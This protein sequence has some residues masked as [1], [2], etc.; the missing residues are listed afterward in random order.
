[1]SEDKAIQCHELGKRYRIG[2]AH[3][4]AKT[5]RQAVHQAVLSPFSYLR[6]KL[7]PPDESEVLWALRDVSFEV[8]RGEVVGVIGANGAGKSTLLKILSRITEPTEGHAVI[9]GRVNSLLEV[10]TGFHPELTGRENMYMAAAIHGMKRAEVNA[11]FDQIVDF[12]GVGKFLDTPLKRY[13]SGMRVRLG[14]AVAAHLSPDVLIVDEVLAVGDLSFQKRCADRMEKAA[15]SGSTVLVVSHRMESIL[16]LCSR[17]ILLE[18]GRKVMEGPAREVVDKYTADVQVAAGATSL[19]EREDRRG[20]GRFRYVDVAFSDGDGTGL[21]QATVGEPFSIHLGVEGEAALASGLTCLCSLNAASGECAT[22]LS[23]LRIG[24]DVSLS[25]RGELEWHIDRMALT[26]GDYRC[27]LILCR[28]VPG[29]PQMEL[30]DRVTDAFT[31]AVVPGDFYGTGKTPVQGTDRFF[32]DHS[33][34]I[35]SRTT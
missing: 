34:S 11:V 19:R 23:S 33:L 6:M 29:T 7:R 13:S 5:F 2:A 8:E 15:G 9:R 18:N 1:M 26:P 35:H 30:F 28:N 31:L 27:N 17:G 22:T 10:G 25:G 16:T 14:F 20:D 4:K 12:S 32:L 21:V 24:C 3:R